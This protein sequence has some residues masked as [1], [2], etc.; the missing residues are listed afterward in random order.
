MSEQIVIGRY[1]RATYNDGPIGRAALAAGVTDPMRFMDETVEVWR[2]E[3]MRS[4]A[5]ASDLC[6]PQED[7]F[8]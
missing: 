3:N 1:E 4:G 5:Y 6:E 2:D 8:S 7:T